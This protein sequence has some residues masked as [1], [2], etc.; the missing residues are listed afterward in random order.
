MEI[1]LRASLD[2]LHLKIDRRNY[3]L[4]ILL[5]LSEVIDTVDHEVLIK[6]LY[7]L[8]GIYGDPLNGSTLAGRSQRVM[9]STHHALRTFP[10]EKGSILS[11]VLFNVYMRQD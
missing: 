3:I 6:C 2:D 4:L 9:L 5:D 8:V 10:V 7:N 11:S 1:M